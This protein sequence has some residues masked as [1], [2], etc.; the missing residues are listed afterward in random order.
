MITAFCNLYMSVSMFVHNRFR[1][2]IN[3]IL[4]FFYFYYILDTI[5]WFKYKTILDH[6]KKLRIN[7]YFS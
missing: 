2:N 6:V 4:T 7:Y 3:N 1:N 5:L